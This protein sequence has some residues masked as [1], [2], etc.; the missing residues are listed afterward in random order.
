MT[1]PAL[2]NASKPVF[3]NS[4]SLTP[5]ANPFWVATLNALSE[6]CLEQKWHTVH[7]LTATTV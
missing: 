4:L 3:F 6:A 7:I 5:L 2:D 1:C